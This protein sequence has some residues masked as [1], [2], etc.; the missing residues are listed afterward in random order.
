MLR[1]RRIYR[2]KDQV[3]FRNAL[4]ALGA[5]AILV[6]ANPYADLVKQVVDWQ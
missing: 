1:R 6:M 4:L 2:K 5:L 3:K